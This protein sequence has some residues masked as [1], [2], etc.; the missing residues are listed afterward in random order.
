MTLLTTL[1]L[2]E[3]A[4]FILDSLEIIMLHYIGLVINL[5]NY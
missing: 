3:H 5:Q 4:Q 1:L 2:Q